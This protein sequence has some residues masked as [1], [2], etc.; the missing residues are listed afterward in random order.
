MPKDVWEG[1]TGLLDDYDLDITS[2]EWTTDVRYQNGQVLLL[3]LTGKATVDGDVVDDH[4]ELIS[5]GNGWASYD[6]RMAQHESGQERGF[7]KSSMIQ[8]WIKR[9]VELGAPIK[10]RGAGPNDA[11]IWV[12]LR[13]HLKREMIEFGQGL[14]SKERT[15]PSAYLGEVGQAAPAAAPAA[16]APAP[17]AT[18]PAAPAAAPAPAN[19]NG[20]GDLVAALSNLAKLMPDEQS[21]RDKAM[22]T[23]P[24]ILDPAN[25]AVLAQVVA[26]DG[27]YAQARA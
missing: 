9:A 26:P 10:G 7:N 12:G 4:E 27:I 3:K 5:C 16:A 8:R 19:G 23:Y 6:G 22:E 24:Q 25:E 2:A 13:F 18:A 17:V 15:L 11:G 21:F 1:E 14:E 20:G